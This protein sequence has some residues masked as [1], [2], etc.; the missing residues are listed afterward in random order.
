MKKSSLFVGALVMFCAVALIFAQE[1]KSAAPS[2]ENEIHELR[3][4]IAELKSQVQTLSSRLDKVEVMMQPRLNPLELK[5]R[6]SVPE[7][8]GIFSPPNAQSQSSIPDSWQKREFNGLSY[9][10]APLAER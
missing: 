6:S 9:Y 8:P 2:R 4:Q 3:Q 5:P 7:S 10:A 1:Q